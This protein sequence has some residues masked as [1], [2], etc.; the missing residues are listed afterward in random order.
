MHQIETTVKNST[1]L[2]ARPASELTQLCKQ[3]PQKITLVSGTN[4]INPKSI[5]SILSG[6]IKQGTTVTVQVDGENEE[7]VCR[8]IVSFIDNLEE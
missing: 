3:F 5:I 6:G 1:G 4:F 7:D 8:Q 2:H